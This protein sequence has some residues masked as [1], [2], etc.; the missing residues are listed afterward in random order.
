[1]RCL[2]QLAQTNFNNVDHCDSTNKRIT[3]SGSIP[4]AA[5]EN[6]KCT[7]A[8][9]TYFGLPVGKNIN[10][11][12]NDFAQRFLEAHCAYGHL[13]FD[14]L[15]KLFGLNKGDKPHCPACAVSM[16]RQAPLNK[17]PDRSTRINHRIHADLGYTAGSKNPFQL[18]VDDHTH[19]SY[20]DLL[21]SKDEVLKAWIE[22]RALLENIHSPWTFAFFRSDNEFVYTSNAWI[23][24]CRETGLEHEF[25]PPYRHDG[26]GVV[27]RAMQTIGV[28]F[29]TMM[30][31]GN[32]PGS[33][34]PY[35]LVHA[36]VIRNHSPSKS[37]NGRTPLEKQAGMKLPINKRLCSGVLFC[38]VYVHVYEEQ[39]VKHDPRG[40]PSVYLGFDAR[41]NQFIAME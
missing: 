12:A 37:N 1:M 21:T 38:L 22:L 28:C 40:I 36:N 20:I 3:V 9:T 25:S 8:N 11:S 4:N 13:H 31:H 16:S 34:I 41:N 39:R 5:C 19:V 7:N 26:L 18:Y 27:E 17:P 29:R 2:P 15:R 10:E 30:L 33:M 23:D 14:K 6:V 32:A 35:A 24:Y